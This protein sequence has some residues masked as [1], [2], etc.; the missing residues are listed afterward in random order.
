MA[1]AIIAHPP[2][3]GSSEHIH[4]RRSILA[5]LTGEAAHA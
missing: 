3:G 5:R 1:E 4:N 2:S